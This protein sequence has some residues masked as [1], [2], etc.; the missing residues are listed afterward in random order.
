MAT[1]VETGV[2]AGRRRASEE[3]NDIGRETSAVRCDQRP[4]M[5]AGKIPGDQVALAIT[6]YENKVGSRA[7]EFSC[8]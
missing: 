4:L 3:V 5:L 1:S 7:V 6:A 2:F 8:K